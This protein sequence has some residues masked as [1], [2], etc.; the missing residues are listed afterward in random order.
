M[1]PALV[2]KAAESDQTPDVRAAE[3]GPKE[4]VAQ[5]FADVEAGSWF[6][7]EIQDIYDRGIMQGLDDVYFGPDVNLSRAQFATILYRMDGGAGGEAYR[8]D[9]TDV[10]DNKELFYLDAVMWASEHKIITGYTEGSE[11][12]KFGPTD[13]ITREQMAAMLYRY[14]VYKQD[15]KYNTDLQSEIP[16]FPDWSAVSEFAE[17]AMEWAAEKGVITGDDGRLNPQGLTSR[18][19]C[20]T[21]IQRF[22]KIEPAEAN[23][24][25]DFSK[26]QGTPLVKKF[27]MFQ[28][29]LVPMERTERD[30]PLL[31]ALGPES[32]RLELGFGA[33]GWIM[34]DA[35][36][37][38]ADNPRFSYEQMDRYAD[39]VREAGGLPYWAYGYNPYP[40]QS[41]NNYRSQPSDLEKWKE[42]L[43]DISAHFREEGVR[44]G[45]QEVWN[46]P[47]C[48]DLFYTGTWEDYCE[49]YK[50]GAAGIL[51]GNPD[52]VIGGPSTAW[53]MDPGTRYADFLNYV[54]GNR[55]PLDFF[56][57]HSYG[58]DYMNRLRVVR[59]ALQAAG[60]DFSTTSVHVNEINSVLNP[61][62]YG[63]DCDHYG[64][65]ADIFRILSDLTEQNDVETVSWAQFLE[66]GV[67]ALGVVDEKG[68]KKA[69]Y[70]AFEIWARMPVDRYPLKSGSVRGLASADDCRAG[71]VLWNESEEAQEITA[72]MDDLPFDRGSVDIYRIDEAHCSYGDGAGEELIPTESYTDRAIGSFTWSSEIPAGGVVYIEANDGL[73]HQEPDRS[74]PDKARIQRQYHYY[75]SRGAS[76]YAYFDEKT[77]TARLGMG[78]VEWTDSIVGVLADHLPDELNIAFDVCGELQEKDRNSL[79]GVR[80]DFETDGGYENS[81]QFHGG[82]YRGD[83]DFLQRWG[84]KKLPDQV[85]EKDLSGFTVKLS[86][87]A[88]ENWTGRA[89]LTFEMQNSGVGTSAKVTVR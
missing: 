79:L 25:V 22:L 81:V 88:P 67:D 84:T 32:V 56:S 78:D 87:Y 7:D 17:E 19:V 13:F 89:I 58:S 5:K 55:L 8:A 60:E 61:W 76:N 72:V 38:T 82:L 18:A 45:Y 29:G 4:D 26:P 83:R 40:L 63:G 1:T 51:E 39:L 36:T 54:K 3:G 20:A 68:R 57:M 11:K 15:H 53:V 28:S 34:S 74:G 27:G 86:D 49:L 16:D 35:I 33:P 75:Y 21:I 70:N 65:A 71:V 23:V 66:S 48:F 62:N 59:Q 69:S 73:G 77:W 85:V 42:Y 30:F 9:F 46:E 52:A 24:S 50:Y 47:D 80:I 31:K 14:A 44:I 64:I 12:G 41:D 43:R 37:G 2:S 6:V 10:P